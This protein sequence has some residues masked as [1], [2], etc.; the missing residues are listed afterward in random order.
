MVTGT[1]TDHVYD[2]TN[3]KC[4]NCEFSPIMSDSDGNLYDE[5]HYEDAFALAAAG[6]VSYVQLECYAENKTVWQSIE[7]NYPDATVTL[8][9]NGVSLISH[10]A[11][12]DPKPA[13]TVSSGTLVIEGDA[14][15]TTADG[16]GGNLSEAA[17]CV[18]GGSLTF[19]GNVTATGGATNSDVYPAIKVTGGNLTFKNTLTATGGSIM[20]ALKDAAPAIEVSGGKVTFEGKVN[21]AGGVRTV[22]GTGKRYPAIKATGGE[23]DFRGG[24]TSQVE[25]D[26]KGGLTLLGDAE[27]THLLTQGK[28]YHGDDAQDGDT[29]AVRGTGTEKSAKYALSLIH[30]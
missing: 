8:K 14:A 9:M 28:F 16:V 7:F 11:N 23:L 29:L 12:A 4:T 1:E 10:N 30:I 13:L 5:E 19:K 22:N 15:I 27:L 20:N 6:K 17:I 18:N 2:E 25:L 3:G 24:N 21:A 26:L